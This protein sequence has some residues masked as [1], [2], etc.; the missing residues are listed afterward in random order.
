[1][2]VSTDGQICF[3]IVF[4]E[5]YEFPWDTYREDG[6]SDPEDWWRSVNGFKPSFEVFDKKGEYLD[7][8][9]SPAREKS[10][11]DYF[12]EG[13]C[14]DKANPIPFE[15]VNYCSDG[16]SM[17]ILAMPGSFKRNSRGYPRKISGMDLHGEVKDAIVFSEFCEKYGLKGEE[18][19]A[20]YLSSYWG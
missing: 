20:W 17:Y 10:A 16:C 19:A 2:S 1:M 7:S 15:L 18:P 11:D 5:G 8:V 6:D 13:R 12:N 3:G 14:W 9:Q 4:E